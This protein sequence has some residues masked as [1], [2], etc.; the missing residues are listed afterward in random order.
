MDSGGPMAHHLGISNQHLEMRKLTE[1]K[2]LKNAR[3]VMKII[4]K[5]NTLIRTKKLVVINACLWE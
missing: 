5:I 3:N 4:I 1:F 2:S